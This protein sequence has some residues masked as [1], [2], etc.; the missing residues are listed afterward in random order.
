MPNLKNPLLSL[1][2]SGSLRN[3]LS[4]ATR[5]NR[6]IVGSRPCVVSPNTPSQLVQR[7]L[8]RNG[9]CAW[10][11]LSVAEK[12]TYRALG[13]LRHLSAFSTYMS[14]YLSATPPPPPPAFV[15]YFTLSGYTGLFM[16]IS[17]WIWLAQAFKV[18]TSHHIA[19][20]SFYAK[21]IGGLPASNLVVSLHLSDEVSGPYGASLLSWQIPFNSVPLVYTWLPFTCQSNPLLMAGQWYAFVYRLDV[22]TF[23]D[24]VSLPYD[25]I[26]VLTS[27]LLFGSP[28]DG[29][30][31]GIVA[32]AT[33][34]FK[35]WG[36]CHT[37]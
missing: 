24:F 31:W 16:P 14:A 1:G 18:S 11:C 33:S 2:A 4:F 17:D 6:Q 23:F 19:Q 12:A 27:V 9:V 29:V 35:E 25:D 34:N 8:Y 7:Q 10:H 13:S 28:D 21:R 15:N 26:G 3:T 20:L 30:S 36:Y 37:P 5:H 32:D 22:G